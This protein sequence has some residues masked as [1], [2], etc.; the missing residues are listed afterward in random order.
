MKLVLAIAHVF[1][2]VIFTHQHAVAVVFVK[3]GAQFLHEIVQ[4][5]FSQLMLEHIAPIFFF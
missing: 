3:N 4:A 2:V 5:G 1:D